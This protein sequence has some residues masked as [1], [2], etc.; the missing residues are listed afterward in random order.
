MLDT[1]QM[2]IG[3]SFFHFLNH[4]GRNGFSVSANAFRNRTVGYFV[5]ENAV[6]LMEKQ[7][8]F[9][10]IKTLTNA[11]EISIKRKIRVYEPDPFRSLC[12]G[13]CDGTL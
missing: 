10:V 2:E 13:F 6:Y 11:M 3:G 12:Q 9:Q 1:D 5:I 4:K 7:Y 8:L